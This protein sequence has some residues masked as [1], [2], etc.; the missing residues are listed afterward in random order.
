MHALRRVY[1]GADLK[2]P[3]ADVALPGAFALTCEPANK[4]AGEE[5]AGL[6]IDMVEDDNRL[7]ADGVLPQLTALL[8]VQYKTCAMLC[9]SRR[10]NCHE[11][12]PVIQ[13]S[14]QQASRMTDPSLRQLQPGCCFGC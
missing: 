8:K 13:Q 1:R 3:I 5:A 7:V 9:Q 10:A 2:Q 12:L 4:E 14:D 6:I 11:P